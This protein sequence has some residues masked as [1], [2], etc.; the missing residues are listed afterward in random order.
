MRTVRICWLAG[1]LLWMA[2]TPSMPPPPDLIIVIAVDTLRADHLGAYGHTRPTSPAIDRWIQSGRLYELALAPSPWTLPSFASLLTGQIPARHAAGEIIDPAGARNVLKL[3][4]GVRTLPEVLRENGFST[5]AIANNVFLAPQFGLHRGFDHY[6]F[7]FRSEETTRRADEVTDRALR[8]IDLRESDSVFLFVHYMDA[9]MNYDAP[10]GFRGRFTAEFQG[11]TRLRHPV[12]QLWEIRSGA[13]ALSD[14]DRQFVAAA[15]DEEIAFLDAQIERLRAGLEERGLLER[16]L[17]VL[18]SDHGEELFEHGGFE[19]GHALWQE[20]VRVPLVFWGPMVAPGRE[21]QPVSLIDIAPTLLDVAG[22]PIPEGV[23]GISLGANLRD[24]EPIPQ[25]TFTFE[26]PLWG[27]KRIGA[28]RWPH[29]FESLPDSDRHRLF[30]L[31]ADPEERDNVGPRRPAIRERLRTELTT[32]LET[33]RALRGP[34]KQADV[35]EETETM[36]RSLGYIE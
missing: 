34:P 26:L 15:Y 29:K 5:G 36:L 11:E 33:A 18:T 6:D 12:D 32:R 14:V 23:E 8:W 27:P 31:D 28:L 17:I 4:S 35:D 19:H 3:D 13:L 7:V 24:A 2:C 1:C 21:Q 20:V 30:D 10:P 9:H 25:R 16:A 22:I